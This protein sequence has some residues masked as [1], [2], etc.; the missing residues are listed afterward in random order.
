MVYGLMGFSMMWHHLMPDK[1]HGIPSRVYIF[2]L[3]FLVFT[4]TGAFDLV[5][6]GELANGAHMGGLFSG[7]FLGLAGGLVSRYRARRT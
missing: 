2:M 4:F 6:F 5:G 7:L 1:H 3:A